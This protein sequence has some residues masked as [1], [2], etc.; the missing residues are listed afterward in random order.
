MSAS[1]T[2]RQAFSQVLP[3]TKK[4]LITDPIQMPEVYSSTPGGTLYSTTPG[5]TKLIY[6]RAFLKDLRA[7]PLSQTP[8]SNLPNCLLRGTPRTPFRKCVPPP[9]DLVKKTQSLKIEDH[10]QFQLEL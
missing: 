4:I 3:R 2:A 9:A 1:P 10:E 7:S 8:P 5:G 6:E